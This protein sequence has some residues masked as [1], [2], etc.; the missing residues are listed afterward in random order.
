[1]GPKKAGAIV[2]KAGTYLMLAGAA[3]IAGIFLIVL[4]NGT[5]PDFLA[6]IQDRARLISDVVGNLVILVWTIVFFGPGYLVQ[7]FGQWLQKD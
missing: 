2:E 6:P 4:V 3:C 7:L 1:M 5:W